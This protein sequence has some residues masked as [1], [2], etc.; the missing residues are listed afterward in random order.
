MCISAG[1]RA[2]DVR[3]RPG[4]YAAVPSALLYPLLYCLIASPRITSPPSVS[5]DADAFD[6]DLDHTAGVQCHGGV[7]AYPPPEGVPVVSRRPEPG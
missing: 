6:P 7:R 5:Q 4:R 1:Q 3:H 2:C